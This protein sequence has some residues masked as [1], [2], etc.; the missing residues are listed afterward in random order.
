MFDLEKGEHWNIL[1]SFYR[2]FVGFIFFWMLSK[3]TMSSKKIL[4]LIR[5]KY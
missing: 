2:E 1:D 4:L 3:S 5:F